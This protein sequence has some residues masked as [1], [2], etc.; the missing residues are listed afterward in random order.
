MTKETDKR[1][2]KIAES[3][4]GKKRSEETKQ[5]MSKAM[6]GKNHPFY[7][8]PRSEQTKLKISLANLNKNPEYLDILFTEDCKQVLLGSLLGDGSLSHGNGTNYYLEETHSSKQ[9]DYLIWKDKI[10]KIFGCKL[11]DKEYMNYK[12]N[13]K[14][15]QVIIKTSSLPL[16]SEY[17]KI[18]YFD[19]KKRITSEILDQINELGLAVWYLDDGHVTILENLVNFSTDSFTYIEH[20]IIK[21]WFIKK[22]NVNPKICRRNNT[23]YIKFNSTDSKKLLAIF[24]VIFE[25]Y[26]VPNCVFYKLGALWEGNKDRITLSRKEKNEYKRAWRRKRREIREKEKLE[27]LREMGGAIKKMYHDECLTISEIGKKLSYSHAGIIKIMK[28]LNIPRRT[29]QETKKLRGQI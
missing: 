4:T 12:L 25:K 22:W 26:G 24:K 9:R 27:K 6:S 3:K 13:K 21:D 14:Y 23:Y 15:P 8:K 18:F 5:K 11:K 1:V 16:L 29:T 10:L 17:H 2:R 7:G 28:K 20:T 19:R